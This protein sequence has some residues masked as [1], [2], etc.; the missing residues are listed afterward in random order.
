MK[1]TVF[2]VGNHQIK[3][4]EFDSLATLVKEKL[5]AQAIGSHSLGAHL[6]YNDA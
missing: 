5:G 6:C 3:E 1:E 2:R 4:P